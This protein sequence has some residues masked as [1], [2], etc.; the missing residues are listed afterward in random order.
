MIVSPGKTVAVWGNIASIGLSFMIQFWK[1]NKRFDACSSNRNSG[2]LY[3]SASLMISLV[4]FARPLLFPWLALSSMRHCCRTAL[5]VVIACWISIFLLSSSNSSYFSSIASSVE[6]IVSLAEGFLSL[7]AVVVVFAVEGFGSLCTVLIPELPAVTVSVDVTWLAFNDCCCWS[8]RDSDRCAARER[9]FSFCSSVIRV[10]SV[11]NS[12]WWRR[13]SS[14]RVIAASAI[15]M[16]K[17][18]ESRNHGYCHM[19]F[20]GYHHHVL[21]HS[22]P[23]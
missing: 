8:W 18:F 1:L 10:V 23:H 21:H 11:F 17:A 15:G 2:T 20:W 19:S 5:S 3:V 22:Q 13:R 7:A 4:S 14:C 9:S 16:S 12:S 6:L